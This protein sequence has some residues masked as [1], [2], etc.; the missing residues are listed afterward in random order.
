MIIAIIICTA[1]LLFFLNRLGN[2][3][4]D[5]ESQRE[6]LAQLFAQ[7]IHRLDKSIQQNRK[8]IARA[9]D[10]LEPE[11]KWWGRN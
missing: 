3:I 4:R 6:R 2:A 5:V 10:M 9:E 8:M 7:E 1:S 11:S